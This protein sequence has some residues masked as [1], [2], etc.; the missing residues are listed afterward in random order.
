MGD[1]DAETVRR[2]EE[3]AAQPAHVYVQL[4]AYDYV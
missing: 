4:P 3:L 2:L 1:D